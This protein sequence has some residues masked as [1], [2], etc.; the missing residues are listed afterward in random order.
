M[1][2]PKIK[3]S[4]DKKIAELEDEIKRREAQLEI[5]LGILRKYEKRYDENQLLP[6]ISAK[7]DLRLTRIKIRMSKKQERIK[8]LQERLRE[9]EEL[10]ERMRGEI[11]EILS[12]DPIREQYEPVKDEFKKATDEDWRIRNSRFKAFQ[13]V[14]AAPG[15]RMVPIETGIYGGAD[16][17]NI[18]LDVCVVDPERINNGILKEFGLG[19]IDREMTPFEKMKVRTGAIPKVKD[20]FE[21][22][23]P[24]LP[25]DSHEKGDSYRLLVIEGYSPEHDGKILCARHQGRQS[26]IKDRKVLHTFDSVYTAYRSAAHPESGYQ[27][28]RAK[29]FGIKLRVD[30]YRKQII[31]MKKDDPK[32]DEIKDKI[33]KEVENF[34]GVINPHKREAGDIIKE[35]QPIK[36]MLGRHNPGRACARLVKAID[37]LQE[38][39]P[40]IMAISEAMH[41]DKEILSTRI[42]Q[43]EAV[44][45]KCFDDFKAACELIKQYEHREENGPLFVFNGEVGLLLKGMAD[46]DTLKVRPFSLYAS[47]LKARKHAIE[48]ALG[49]GD[50]CAAKKEAVKGFIIAKIFRIQKK[51]EEMLKDIS[52]MPEETSIATLLGIAEELHGVANE[53]QVFPFLRT[54][55]ERTYEALEQSIRKLAE[56]LKVYNQAGLEDR[57]KLQMYKRLKKYL[58]DL[59]FLAILSQ[60][61]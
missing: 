1:E 49:N 36:D 17:D 35:V 48:C 3:D 23:K 44:M 47:N 33:S 39:F 38:R 42:M 30:G 55:Y 4:Y 59:D 58:E 6:G 34:E 13:D 29:L 26:P 24:M 32:L 52:L 5:E 61:N 37:E 53:R 11:N 51:S 41:E 54:E 27:D 20:L 46:F 57:Q 10:L 2:Y 28:E 7:D 22:T 60:L 56:G 25:F 40:E 16:Y 8:E 19:Q 45:D 31:G 14:F 43:D 21:H 12:F 9:K 15:Y 50:F 18:P